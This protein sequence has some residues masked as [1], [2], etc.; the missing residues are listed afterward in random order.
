MKKV[1][2]F[3]SSLLP[4][5]ETFIRE[6]ALALK[7]WQP[8][9]LGINRVEDG[10]EIAPL[11]SRVVPNLRDNLMQRW[12]SKSRLT[13][14]RPLPQ[15]ISTLEDIKP[16][17]VHV[18]FGTDAVDIWSTIKALG[19]PMLVTLHGYDIN[20]YKEWWEKGNSPI[21]RHRFYPKRLLQLS[22]HPKVRFIAVSNA[23]K[24]RAVVYGIDE[25]KIDVS[26]IGVDTS[27]FYPSGQPIQERKKRILFVGRMVE[28]KAPLLLIRAFAKLK[29]QTP[30]AELV[31][32]GDG[33]LKNDAQKLA[34]ALAVEINFKGAL[35]SEQVLEE[36]HQAQ[37][38]CLPS[39]TAENGDAEGLPISILEAQACGIP[40]VTTLHSGNPEGIQPNLT[41]FTV[42]EN[43]I[44]SLAN[45]L[46]QI[47]SDKQLLQDMSAS[48][49][50]FIKEVMSNKHILMGL[51]TLYG[52]ISN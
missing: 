7:N 10:L 11:V 19:I 35:T 42:V 25:S 23:I 40:V 32:I 31:M 15:L 18:H 39:I 34:Q 22:R 9:L 26:Y 1:V 38:F 6:Q 51:E 46:T 16:N 29:K 4:I 13:L 8:I 24:Q 33:P 2:V 5:S 36:L 52:K 49:L 3:R 45:A 28:K 48:S 30:D 14:G 17:L 47:L 41:G 27:K 12:L 50:F 37:V 43:D 44:E 20:I 21:F